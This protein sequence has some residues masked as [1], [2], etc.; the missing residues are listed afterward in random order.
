MLRFLAGRIEHRAHVAGKVRRG[1]KKECRL[2]DARFAAEQHQRSRDDA[3]AQDAIELVDA[4]RE[5]R[6]V[7]DRD[8]RVELRAAGRTELR[9]SIRGA[10]RRL[11]FSRAFLDQLDGF[12]SL[13]ET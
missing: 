6:G 1:L 12:M 13:P 9:V 2:P 4:G 11:G 10:R 5:P 3:A 8:I 7:G